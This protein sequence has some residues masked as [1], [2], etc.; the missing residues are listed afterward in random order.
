MATPDLDRLAE[1]VK[2]HRLEQYSS[3]DAAAAAAGI[4]RNTWKR[5][6]EG[7]EV[8]ESTYVKVDKALGWA[9]GSCIAIIEGGDPV[10]ADSPTTSSPDPAPGMTE[11]QARDMAWDTA[12]ATLPTAPVGELDA[13]VNELVE[14]LRRAGIVTD[15]P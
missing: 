10:F 5:V 12:R 6:E 8:Y 4:S 2:M 1:R 14:N 3:R 7:Q 13:F 11:K 9:T 15:G